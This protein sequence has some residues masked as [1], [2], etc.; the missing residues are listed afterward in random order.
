MWTGKGV[1]TKFRLL[2]N[3]HIITEAGHND[4]NDDIHGLAA[5]AL[6]YLDVSNKVSFF[7]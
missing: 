2:Y 1:L 7:S 5:D 4:T 3:L 6:D